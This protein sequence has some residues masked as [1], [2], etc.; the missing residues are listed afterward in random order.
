MSC[1]DNDTDSDECNGTQNIGIHRNYLTLNALHIKLNK[2]SD[3][4]SSTTLTKRQKFRQIRRII[5]SIVKRSVNQNG[6]G[7]YIGTWGEFDSAPTNIATLIIDDVRGELNL[8]LGICNI[9]HVLHLPY[10]DSRNVTR[11]PIQRYPVIAGP[12]QHL[13][14]E[15]GSS[16][17][18]AQVAYQA[19]PNPTLPQGQLLHGPTNF[20][21]SSAASSSPYNVGSMSM[22]GFNPY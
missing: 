5:A 4:V 2:I 14:G 6:V 21:A 1:H 22:G 12:T 13:H 3:L 19:F 9:Y 16:G 15:P 20:G 18:V 7:T 8:N 17:S 10:V 11:H